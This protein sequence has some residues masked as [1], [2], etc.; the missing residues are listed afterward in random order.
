MDFAPFLNNW[1]SSNFSNSTSLG[2]KDV[3][4]ETIENYILNV[5]AVD[6]NQNITFNKEAEILDKID[7]YI[8]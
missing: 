6:G 1:V 8:N 4:K 5:E 2:K 7:N 3:V